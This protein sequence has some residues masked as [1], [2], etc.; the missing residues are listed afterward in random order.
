MQKLLLLLFWLLL[1]SCG[2]NIDR[3]DLENLNGYWEIEEV[4]DPSGHSRNY[5]LNATIDFLNLEGAKGYRKKVQPQ[6]DGTFITSDDAA[7]FSIKRKDDSY[8][9]IYRD[10]DSEWEEQL[11]R[12]GPESFSVVN[13]ENYT[14]HYKRYQPLVTTP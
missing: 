3:A 2:R 5:G 11:V 6:V 10:G 14:Y 1:F 7:F 12:L 8:Y 13:Q 9:M 4:E